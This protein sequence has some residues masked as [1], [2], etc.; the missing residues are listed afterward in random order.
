MIS[1]KDK[2]QGKCASA[3]NRRVVPSL[4][5]V[6][7]ILLF[8]VGC[9]VPRTPVGP[10]G[11]LDVITSVFESPGGVLP[12]DWAIEAGGEA[13]EHI[14]ITEKEGVPAIR[15]VNGDDPFI[16][17][18]RVQAALLATPYLKW[19]WHMTP[20]RTGLHPVRLMI[21]F[22]GG[23]PES[24]SWG[25]EP[26]AWLGS[27]LPPHDRVLSIVFGDSALK[28]GSLAQPPREGNAA[29]LYTARGGMENA[30][31]WWLEDV[32]LS[33]LYARAWPGDELGRVQVV[34]IGVAAAGGR[35]PS[36]GFFSEI[37]LYR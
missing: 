37:L 1:R 15:V 10:E 18:K 2:I 35:A 11:T 32:D 36:S 31:Q 5:A 29:A 14:S 17:V 6:F 9:A 12:G 16:A 19:A 4:F 27:A 13:H 21:G 3:T 33:H 26:F 28:R 8:L 25:G 30:S 24:A 22:H 34:F 23:H 7:F 20:H